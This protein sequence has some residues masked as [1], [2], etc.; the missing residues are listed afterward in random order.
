MTDADLKAKVDSW[1]AMELSR[2]IQPMLSGLG[3]GAQGVVLAD[4]L[5]IW[6]AGHHRDIRE[7]ALERWTKLVRDM[8]PESI[9][10]VYCGE[11]PEGYEP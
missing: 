8:L 5:S 6:L 9:G 7:E 10:E 4:L 3:P 11:P 2:K 1:T